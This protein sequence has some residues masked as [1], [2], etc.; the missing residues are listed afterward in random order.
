VHGENAEEVRL[1]VEE[2]GMSPMQA[3]VASTK[4]SA[5][6]AHVDDE[7]GTLELGKL[8]DLLIVNGNP[9]D[10]ISILEDKSNLKM[11]MQSGNPYKD[12]LRG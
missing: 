10:D 2:G 12:L 5:E 6:C 4:T 3:I 9:L 1:L 8:A 11:I 7:V